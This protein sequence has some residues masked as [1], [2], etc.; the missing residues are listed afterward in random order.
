[1]KSICG[2][3]G[4]CTSLLKLC[5]AF[6]SPMAPSEAVAGLCEFVA[7]LCEFAL[8]V[9]LELHERFCTLSLLAVGAG[10]TNAGPSVGVKK[11]KEEEKKRIRKKNA[12]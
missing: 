10:F 8:V 1:M 7:G 5:T 11:E 2:A 3:I 12:W 4:L 9:M 6:S